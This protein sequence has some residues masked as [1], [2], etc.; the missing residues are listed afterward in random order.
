MA[1]ALSGLMVVISVVLVV[2]G[3]RAISTQ[4]KYTV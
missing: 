4:D 2:V 1:R 3:G